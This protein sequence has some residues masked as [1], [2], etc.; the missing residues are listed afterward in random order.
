MNQTKN[1]ELKD[2]LSETDKQNNKSFR[3]LSIEDNQETIPEKGNESPAVS[4]FISLRDSFEKLFNTQNLFF[5]VFS[6]NTKKSHKTELEKIKEAT[7]NFTTS[8]S[9]DK[10]VK[11][12]KN[13][14]TQ[15]QQKP[16]SQSSTTAN[17]SKSVSNSIKSALGTNTAKAIA[18]T[19][20]AAPAAYTAVSKLSKSKDEPKPIQINTE[21]DSDIMNMIKRHEGVR[22]S[23][24]KDSLGKWTIGVGHLIGNG[25]TLP[26][27]YNR[28]FSKEEIDAMFAE[29]Y[30]KH[31]QLAKRF[32]NYDSLPKPAKA[33]VIDMTYQMGSWWNKWK[34]LQAAVGEKDPEK[35]EQELKNSSWYKQTGKERTS[36]IISLWKQGFG[37]KTKKDFPQSETPESDESSVDTYSENFNKYAMNDY[38]MDSVLKPLNNNVYIDNFHPD[39]APKVFE[40]GKIYK[41]LTGKKLQV[42]EGYRTYEEQVRLY[43]SKPRGM[44]AYPGTSLHGYGLAIDINSKDADKLESAGA[45][46][47]LGLVRPI[48]KEKWHVEPI[49]AKSM[50]K[51]SPQFASNDKTIP[52]RKSKPQESKRIT[53]VHATNIQK[54]QKNIARTNSAKD[55]SYSERMS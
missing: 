12:T 21:S 5:K 47:K 17:V 3:N 29:D 20:V 11:P 33:A 2:I 53:V 51:D 42:N 22:Y 16:T 44:A 41:E 1:I 50:K 31:K 23:P 19:S 28:E 30:K 7:E 8:D 32:P 15:K 9:K 49:G 14:K 40:M 4:G 26:K 10:T 24:Y 39:F 43:K 37:D 36:T 54:N 27:E 13:Y 45:F 34:G 25:S 48:K 18:A 38:D 35:I 55:K 6:E 46:R 52:N